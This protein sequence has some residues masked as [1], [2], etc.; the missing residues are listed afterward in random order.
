[1][2]SSTGQR[3]TRNRLSDPFG[4]TDFLYVIVVPLFSYTESPLSR[5][6]RNDISRHLGCET[7]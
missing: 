2:V 7:G 1:M 3:I 5:Y 4:L 6:G